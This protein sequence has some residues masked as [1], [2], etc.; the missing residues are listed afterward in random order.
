MTLINHSRAA[1]RRHALYLALLP[2]VVPGVVSGQTS[3][4]AAV[5]GQA[6]DGNSD[7]AIP[8]SGA[9]DSAATTAA[10]AA[11]KLSAVNVTAPN[12]SDSRRYEITNRVV[13]GRKE[14]ERHNDN[15]LSDVMRRLPGVTVSPIDGV[16]M[17]GLGGGYVQILVDGSPVS[18]DFSL[19]SISPDLIERIEILPTAVAEYSTKAI[20]GTI[21]VVLR[22][23]GSTVQR[24]LKLN[25][26]KDGGEWY[27]SASMLLSDKHGNLSWSLNAVASRPKSRIHA[28]IT[29]SESDADGSIDSLRK[30]KELFNGTTTTFNLAPRLNWKFDEDNALTWNSLVQHSR[31]EWTRDR[32]ENVLVGGPTDYPRNVWINDSRAWS[33]R[34]D[35]NWK[36]TY[37]SGATLNAKLGLNYLKRDTNFNFLGFSPTGDFALDRQVVSDAIDRNYTTTGKYLVQ[38]G[39]SHSIALGWDGAYTAR[40]EARLQHDL[41]PQG[42]VLDIID[43]SYRAGVKRIAL[44]AQDE[45]EARDSLQIY[46]GARWEGLYTHVEGPT[47]ASVGND[48]SVFS[49]IVQAVWKVPGTKKDQVRFGVARTFSSPAPRTLVP[50]RYTVNNGNSPTN[51]DIQGNPD[52]LPEIAWGVDAAYERYFGENAMISL[53]AYAR[54]IDEVTINRLF[55][56]DGIW[57]SMPVNA[58]QARTHGITLEAKFSLQDL[59]K[60]DENIQFHGN[61]TRNWS[62]VDSVPGPDNHLATQTPFSG[63]IGAEWVASDSFSTGF[64]FSYSGKSFTRVSE[65]WSTG[66][67]PG[68]TLDVYATLKLDKK[69][70]LTLSLSN[71]LHQ[72][73]GLTTQFNAPTSRNSRLYATDSDTGIKLQ[74]ERQL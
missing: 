23:H 6:A 2:L 70:K 3:P 16:R 41:D 51:P 64:D 36:H 52:L 37:E 72:T 8:A 48:S 9:P 28:L 69:S 66:T 61:L 10:Q 63:T 26:G 7:T 1:L 47:I 27:P 45:W 56:Q 38:A 15:N 44:Y 39:D 42:T 58:G 73:D 32:Q 13:F 11:T 22:N 12:D 18:S 25:A 31:E 5:R 55:E 50:R 30:T 62:S 53:S 20:A 59:I 68:R 21:N 19:D 65:F 34:T 24:T 74:F 71:L 17:R 33:G 46:L 60:T 43:E 67:S 14:I 40:S 4:P 54:R 35:L 49:P 29:D 57:I